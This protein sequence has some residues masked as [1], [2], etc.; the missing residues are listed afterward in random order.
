MESVWA[1]GVE[2]TAA[3]REGFAALKEARAFLSQSTPT[4]KDAGL[5][6]LDAVERENRC[7]DP[8]CEDLRHRMAV[9]VLTGEFGR[10]NGA[11]IA[12]AAAIEPNEREMQASSTLAARPM[13]EPQRLHPAACPTCP[14]GGAR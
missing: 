12:L 9:K 3:R 2:D 7:G 5:R 1:E 11:A 14:D 13:T 6:P 4:E 10:H 8:L